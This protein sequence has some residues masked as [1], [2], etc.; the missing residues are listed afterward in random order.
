MK[1]T[2][3]Y[4]NI[5][6]NRMRK[7][8]SRIILDMIRRYEPIS[9]K[10][11]AKVTGLTAA[12]VTNI[13]NNLIQDRFLIE[14][15]TG[16]AAASSGRRPIMLGLNADIRY[17]IGLELT[18]NEIRCVL[19]NFKGSIKRKFFCN[20]DVRKG[21][22]ETVMTICDLILQMIKKEHLNKDD[23]LGI[24]LVSAGPLDQKEGIM[25][26]PP[27]FPGWHEI[28]I[29][30]MVENGTGIR[31]VFD[32][33]VNGMAIGEQMFGN[34]SER[35]NFLY[36]IVNDIGVGAGVILDGEIYHGYQ[37]GAGN[38]GHTVL[39]PGGPKCSC[40]RHGCVEALT[41]G[42]AIV[43]EV[44]N[45]V[46]NGEYSKAGTTPALIDLQSVSE[47]YHRGDAVCVR[48]VERAA[49]YTGIVLVNLMN[50]YS[51]EAIVLAGN[52]LDY[53]PDFYEKTCEYVRKEIGVFLIN[54]ARI[55]RASFTKFGAAI[56]GVGLVLNQF[57][58]EMSE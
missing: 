28:P 8:N 21:P 53:M 40:G 6:N 45:A 33:E 43:R 35:H 17:I 51:P 39:L 26:N 44:R 50:A 16:E 55:F 34:M 36:Y 19:A 11:L 27:N 46:Q 42:I 1:I 12:T 18:V 15:G 4:D 13:V 38:I 49:E 41:S 22:E 23:I 25:I 54:E 14:H 32:K 20:I 48:E 37:D 10:Q 24:G 30:E 52:L 58:E 29:K 47:A 56:G 5:N 9:R 3:R 57:T 7:I 31:V 2:Y